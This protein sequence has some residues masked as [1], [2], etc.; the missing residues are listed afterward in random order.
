MLP[1]Y[2]AFFDRI[3]ELHSDIEK[4]FAGMPPEGLD[5]VP[6]DDMNSMAV[7]VTHT[8][9]AERYWICA[10][11]GQVPSDRDRDE[12]FRTTGVNEASL[13]QRLDDELADVE[14]TLESLTLED[15][16]ADRV[17]H[18]NQ[19]TFTVGW[20]ILHAMEHTAMHLGH[21]QMLRQ[22]WDQR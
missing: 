1:F 18:R 22:L 5:W 16:A 17:S 9:E 10:V 6:G 8:A 13:K 20:S 11:A 14:K 21:M 15:L 2:E 4:C 3:K 12:E 19:R 7:L